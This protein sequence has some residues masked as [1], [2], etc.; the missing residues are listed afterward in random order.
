[1]ETAFRI[2]LS[3][4][5]TGVWFIAIHWIWTNQLDP[6][7]TVSRFFKK[8]VEPPDWVATRE[9]S[10]IYQNGESVGDIIGA[11]EQA[12]GQVHFS[13]I[14]NTTRFDT[15]SPFEYQRL[16]LKVVR[17]GSIIGMKS[18]V[19]DK[20]AVTLSAVMEDVTCSIIN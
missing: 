14:A 16:K 1:M 8:T 5:F 10:K 3:F 19:T 6:R 7:E 15:T 20:G 4:I 9:P 17:I 11:V 2:L 13:Q 12:P 18:E